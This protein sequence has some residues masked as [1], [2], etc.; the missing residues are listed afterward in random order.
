MLK[1]F[2]F[3][4]TQIFSS[5]SNPAIQSSTNN[6][7]NSISAMDENKFHSFI[8]N[9]VRQKKTD[10]LIKIFNFDQIFKKVATLSDKK[11]DLAILGFIFHL[12]ILIFNIIV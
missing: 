5:S 11:P 8:A 10:V 7:I 2:I 4:L 3:Y 12:E 6:F 9:Y 1:N